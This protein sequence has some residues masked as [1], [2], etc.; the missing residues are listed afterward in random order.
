VILLSA[1]FSVTT[2]LTFNSE[3]LIQSGTRWLASIELAC[4]LDP[5]TASSASLAV[6]TL[7]FAIFAVVTASLAIS[8][9]AIV[10]STKLALA[11]VISVGNAPELS[12]ANVTALSAILA[13]VTLASAILAVVTLE[14]A[15]LAVVTLASVILAVVTELLAK[16][17]ATI[18]PST[19]SSLDINA[20]LVASVPNIFPSISN[21]LF[22]ASCAVKL[23]S[24]NAL[25]TSVCLI[26]LPPTK[27]V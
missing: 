8:A 1:I 11:I 21:A 19:I 27:L 3:L 7:A 6:V 17:P 2:Q 10:P 24:S 25:L 23:D 13:V 9:V 20:V 4:I 16:S 22:L 26:V 15:I 12:F 5:I 14:S 18:V